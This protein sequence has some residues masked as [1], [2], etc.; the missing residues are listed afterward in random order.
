MSNRQLIWTLDTVDSCSMIAILDEIECWR[1]DPIATENDADRALISTATRAAMATALTSPCQSWLPHT[2]N[3]YTSR[4]ST[5]AA[6]WLLPQTIW[7]L[8]RLVTVPWLVQLWHN[9]HLVLVPK[10][11][12][13]TIP[14]PGFLSWCCPTCHLPENK[15]QL[16]SSHQSYC[17]HHSYF[18]LSPKQKSC[19]SLLVPK[20]DDQKGV[21]TTKES[22]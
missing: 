15:L 21:V 18:G 13:A 11:I 4:A 2:S 19:W 5:T 1:W 10:A 20:Q 8:L 14:D 7:L 3:T 12:T 6:A 16:P 22:Y 9:S 17:C